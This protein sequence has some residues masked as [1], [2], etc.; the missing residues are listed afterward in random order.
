MYLLASM[1]S[2]YIKSCM[3]I[4]FQTKMIRNT[5]ELVSNISMTSWQVAST[6]E[7]SQSEHEK[8]IPFFHTGTWYFLNGIKLIV[9]HKSWTKYEKTYR[10]RPIILLL[11]TS[12]IN[13]FLWAQYRWSLRGIFNNNWVSNRV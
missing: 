5:I 7:I 2:K 6:I 4:G 3:D 10:R 12:S 1:A 8:M 13:D 9:Y 11:Q